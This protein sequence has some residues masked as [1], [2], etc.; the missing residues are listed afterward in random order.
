LDHV[1]DSAGLQALIIDGKLLG[2]L[3][4]G[5]PFLPA[6]G[7]TWAIAEMAEI[8]E[9]SPGAD[10]RAPDEGPRPGSLGKIVHPATGIDPNALRTVQG[11][12]DPG[13]QLQ[14]WKSG[15][16]VS[17]GGRKY[18]FLVNRAQQAWWP[19]ANGLSGYLGHWGPFVEYDPSDNRKSMRFP[20]FWL[21]FFE[22]L[23]KFQA[24]P[25][26]PGL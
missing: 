16:N 20:R 3:A 21:M 14:P 10:V 6:A 22:A 24:R 18:D 17:I 5:V 2:G 19:S 15:Q 8:L 26:F 1:H 12:P 13:A 25:D 23:S 7:L 9:P 4:L 11:V